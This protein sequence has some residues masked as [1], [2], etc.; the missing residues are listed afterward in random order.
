M[1]GWEK[2]LETKQTKKTSSTKKRA[3]N[4]NKREEENGSYIEQVKTN[5]MKKNTCF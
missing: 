5:R 2:K 4:L 1:S 3:K